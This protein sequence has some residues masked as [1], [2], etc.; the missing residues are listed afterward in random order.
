MRVT[1]YGMVNLIAGRPIVRE[2]IQEHFTAQAVAD[3]AIS[4][5]RDRDRAASMRRDLEEV[6]QTGGP[7]A[8]RRAAEVIAAVARRESSHG[9]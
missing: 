1:T 9:L 5:L 7:G 8:S 2:L 6:S 3:E 4:L